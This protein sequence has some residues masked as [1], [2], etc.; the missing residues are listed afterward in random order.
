MKKEIE[1]EVFID[2]EYETVHYHASGDSRD[3]LTRVSYQ[4][5]GV[6]DSIHEMFE[7]S[8]NAKLVFDVPEKKIE[9]S[10]SDIRNAFHYDDNIENVLA[11]LG[12]ENE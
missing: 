2:R 9:L 6:D 11:K 1:C 4:L 3:I 7:N 8:F 5:A 12:F 10:E